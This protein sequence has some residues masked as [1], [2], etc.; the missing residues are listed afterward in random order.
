MPGQD[1]PVKVADRP[2]GLGDNKKNR[3]VLRMAARKV[4]LEGAISDASPPS[5]LQP[6]SPS[7]HAND[8]SGNSFAPLE[9]AQAPWKT[10]P[11]TFGFAELE[12]APVPWTTGT[13]DRS[14]CSSGVS[15]G[16]EVQQR[17]VERSSCPTLPDQSRATDEDICCHCMRPIEDG[18]TSIECAECGRHVH[19]YGMC[20]LMQ[21]CKFIDQKKNN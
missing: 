19:Y 2:Y 13:H 12:A 7:P 3:A 1:Y 15:R 17:S 9:A 5:R 14:E 4:I 11:A 18:H 21:V 6:Q 20:K 10:R 16:V 8:G